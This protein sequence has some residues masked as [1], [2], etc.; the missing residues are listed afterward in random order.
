M[1][2][3]DKKSWRFSSSA[4]QLDSGF[5]IFQTLSYEST[6]F[7][8]LR[9]VGTDGF[10]IFSGDIKQ[11]SLIKYKYR[12]NKESDEDWRKILLFVFLGDREPDDDQNEKEADI[13]SKGL[14]D[15]L[16]IISIYDSK[17]QK[18][19]LTIRRKLIFPND[20][21]AG[22]AGSE[23]L[24]SKLGTVSF[25]ELPENTEVELDTVQWVR[26]FDIERQRWQERESM[27]IKQIKIQQNM[28]EDLKLQFECLLSAKQEFEDDIYEK[29]ALIIN[30]HKGFLPKKGIKKR[31]T[32]SVKDRDETPDSSSNYRV[33][34]EKL[35]S[36][37]ELEDLLDVSDD[38]RRLIYDLDE[39]PSLLSMKG[40][41]N[42][43]NERGESVNQSLLVSE[44]KPL[45]Y[46]EETT[47]DEN[48]DDGD[49]L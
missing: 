20:M 15:N 39:L 21:E 37:H 48:T 44:E 36:D 6:K 10:T 9:I 1:T 49:F 30:E 4:E 35:S 33:K 24:Y 7:L 14:Y 8:D 17:T 31:E 47:D 16:N 41:P 34:I 18:L 26:D 29:V 22:E 46:G 11:Q 12:R 45:D 19:S 25:T 3:T 2:P 32:P 27:M 38:N 28:I 5:V 42:S 13:L 43:L 23:F 40:E